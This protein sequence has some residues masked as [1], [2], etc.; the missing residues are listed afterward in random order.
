MDR[1]WRSASSSS[2]AALQFLVGIDPCFQALEAE[3]EVS[4]PLMLAIDAAAAPPSRYVG[5]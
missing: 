2:R 5:L 4:I 3:L 1:S